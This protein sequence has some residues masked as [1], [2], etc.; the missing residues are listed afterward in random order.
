MPSPCDL[1]DDLTARYPAL[2]CVKDS[3]GK[4]YKMMEETYSNDGT[5]F[6]CGN[7]GSAADS[8]HIV[9]ELMKGFVK[10][11]PLDDAVKKM[12][13]EKFG[14][15]GKDLADKLQRGLKAV[16]LSAHPG[17]MTAFMN[18]VDATLVY[19]QKLSVMGRKGDTLIGISTSGGSKIVAAALRVA[20][21][22]GI[23]TITLTGE[24]DSLCSSLADCAIK[25]PG[26]ETYKI[27]EY[28][29]PVYHTLCLM[30]EERFFGGSK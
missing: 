29:L 19:A 6:V 23:K 26:R 9:G 15:I 3:V 11:R 18:D 27:Q 12:Y 28:H 7:G 25:V 10:K 22:A 30:I 16:C 13:A 5:V 14:D 17:L 1:L 20:K 4:A 8:D 21:V 24:A 2:C